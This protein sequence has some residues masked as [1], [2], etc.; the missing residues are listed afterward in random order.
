MLLETRENRQYSCSC[1]DFRHSVFECFASPLQM[2]TYSCSANHLPE[3]PPEDPDLL[4][5]FTSLNVHKDQERKESLRQARHKPSPDRCR[6]VLSSVS[7]GK[8]RQIDGQIGEVG[9]NLE[10]IAPSPSQ[11][12]SDRRFFT[13][14]HKCHKFGLVTI[15]R[16]LVPGLGG[17]SK[18]G[19]I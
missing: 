16:D 4:F 7:I 5:P 9:H 3:R 10:W 13:M 8:S 11:F 6:L 1:A 14:M 19:T 17:S 12:A 15:S 2:S 18:G